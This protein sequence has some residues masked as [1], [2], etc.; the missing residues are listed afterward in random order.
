MIGLVW[1]S[2][3]G[4][5]LARHLERAWPDAR[6]YPGPPGAALRAAWAECDGV[7]AFMAAGIAVRLAAPLLEHKD[8]DPGLV[9][10]D[11]AGRFAVA[12]AGGHGGGANRL[13]TRVAETLGATPVITTASETLALPALD[14]LGA[15]LGF[16]VEA[17]SDLAAVAAAM[18]GGDRVTLVSDQ[19]WPLPPLPEAIVAAHE[20]RPPCLLITDRIV[21]PPRPAV[22]FR[23]QSLVVGV[24]C[25]RG[26][27]AAEIGELVDGTLE[28]AGL[29]ASSVAYLASVD[30]KRDEPGLRQTAAERG[31]P[32]RFQPSQA[33][34]R[35]AVPNP[36]AAVAAAVGTPSVAEAAALASGRATLVV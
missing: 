18:V 10:V 24:G 28:E 20:P 35:V 6:A 5:S 9:C 16:T 23:P 29:A 7:V 19:R 27:P 14:Q 21:E 17:G 32:L 34:A 22:V 4:E 13:A 1:A 12:L 30:A 26:A 15:D 25:S 8:R 36:S 2:R 11:D 3:T 33:L 31:W